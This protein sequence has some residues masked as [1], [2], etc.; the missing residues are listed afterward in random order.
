MRTLV[1]TGALAGERG[2]YRL[3]TPLR[4]HP[5]AGHGPGDPGRADDRLPLEDKTLLQTAAVIGKDVPFALLQAIGERPED[6]L[7]HG[8]A[9]LQAAEFLYETV[10]FPELEYTFKHALT[11]EVAYGGLLQERRRDLHAP[12]VGPSRACIRGARASRRRLTLHAFR[13]EFW[14]WAAAHLLGSELPSLDGYLTGFPG[15][16][17]AGA[18]GGWVTTST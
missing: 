7:R 3:A 2:G 8:L 17:S 14:D 4:H 11:Q 15:P 12:I 6:A 9:R 16:E 13:G 5:G 10:L 1:E 18:P